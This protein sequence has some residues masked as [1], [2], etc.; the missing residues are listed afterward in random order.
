MNKRSQLRNRSLKLKSVSDSELI[1]RVFSY[2]WF[3]FKILLA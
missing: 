1:Y 2:S 3:I